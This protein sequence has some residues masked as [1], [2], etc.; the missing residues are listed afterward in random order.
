MAEAMNV[1][2]G[3]AMVGAKTFRVERR[4]ESKEAVGRESK[5]LRTLNGGPI[6]SCGTARN[7]RRNVRRVEEDRQILQAGIHHLRGLY[8]SADL[9]RQADAMSTDITYF[10]A[11]VPEELM[12]HAQRPSNDRWLGLIHDYAACCCARIRCSCRGYVDGLQP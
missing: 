9:N 10:N 5:R 4:Q 11:V 6:C 8:I 3:N 1:I 12:L 2:A 7:R